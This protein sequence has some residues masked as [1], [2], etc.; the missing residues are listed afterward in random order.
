MREHS[1][2]PMKTIKKQKQ[3]TRESSSLLGLSDAVRFSL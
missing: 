1:L 3:T 2:L